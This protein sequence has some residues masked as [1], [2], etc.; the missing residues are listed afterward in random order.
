M[1]NFQTLEEIYKALIAGKKIHM[2]GDGSGYWLQM[3]GGFLKEFRN[4]KQRL[5]RSEAFSSP[6][7]WEEYVESNNSSQIAEDKK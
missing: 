3:Q 1:G 4:E 2:V 7:F 6:S 5:I